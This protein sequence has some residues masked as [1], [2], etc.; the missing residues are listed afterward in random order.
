MIIL[1]AS[2]MHYLV[3]NLGLF[4]GDLVP[5]DSSVWKLYEKIMRTFG[6]LK[7]FSTMRFEAKHKQIKEYSKVT[8]FRIYL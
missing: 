6:P 7:N 1:S 4:L 8:T 5:T 3:L 2:E